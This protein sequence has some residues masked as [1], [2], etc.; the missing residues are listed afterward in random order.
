MACH[1]APWVHASRITQPK[2]RTLYRIN[3]DM[4]ASERELELPGYRWSAPVRRGNGNPRARL[5][6]LG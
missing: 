5:Y 3:G 6:G 2:I 4:E 1:A